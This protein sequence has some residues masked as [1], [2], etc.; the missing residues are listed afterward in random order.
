M[1]TLEE[2][3]KLAEEAMKVDERKR[4]YNVMYDLKAPSEEM[5]E[6]YRRKRQREEDPMA[7]FL[8]N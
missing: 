5:M 7:Q 3:D 2:R 8:N 4:P 1:K 6:A